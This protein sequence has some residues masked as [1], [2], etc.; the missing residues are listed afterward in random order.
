ME[1]WLINWT[2]NVIN[3]TQAEF[4]G[5]TYQD[6]AEWIELMWEQ[7][8]SN[9]DLGRELSKNKSMEKRIWS[10]TNKLRESDSLP[11]NVDLYEPTAL[12]NSQY[13]FD[14]NI[15]INNETLYIVK[16]EGGSWDDFYVKS[17]FVTTNKNTASKYCGKADEV[18][19]RIKD[20]YNEVYEEMFEEED[21]NSERYKLLMKWWC[22]LEK[23]HDVNKH[24][25]E[26]IEVR[27]D[28]KI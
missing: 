14:K 2:A 3:N 21:M 25:Y 7:W 16:R 12:A 15:D 10:I 17:L 8:L 18:F 19:K 11:L 28:E 20:R 13:R 24:Y 23:Y 1:S 22:K 6:G 26:S 4:D 27:C 5:V 9:S